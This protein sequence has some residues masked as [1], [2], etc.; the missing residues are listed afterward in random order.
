MTLSF[1]SPTQPHDHARHPAD[2]RRANGMAIAALVLGIVALVLFWT[3]FGGIVLGLAAVVLGIIGARRAR[4]GRAPHRTMSVV[5]AVLGALALI[6]SVVILAIG[7]SV[8]GS[9]EYEN[10][11]ECVR[12]ATSQGERQACER[13]FERDV[14]D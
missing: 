11:D 13:D 7:A 9:D 14:N 8:L 4:G 5:G 1:S 12:N 2:A 3:V 10:F 6:V